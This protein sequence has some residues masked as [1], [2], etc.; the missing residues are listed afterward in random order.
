[1]EGSL[2][3]CTCYDTVSHRLIRWNTPFCRL[4]NKPGIL[5]TYSNPD[6]HETHL[7]QESFNFSEMNNFYKESSFTATDYDRNTKRSEHSFYATDVHNNIQYVRTPPPYLQC[8][9]LLPPTCLYN[10]GHLRQPS[11]RFARSHPTLGS[12]RWMMT[13]TYSWK[14]GW[15]IMHMWAKEIPIKAKMEQLYTSCG[16]KV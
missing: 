16:N 4:F 11:L 8:L 6:P 3:C 15:F 12:R 2:S 9:P 13:E 1:M 5:R 14:L 7:W 10:Y